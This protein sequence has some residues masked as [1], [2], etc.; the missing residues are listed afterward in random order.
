MERKRNGEVTTEFESLLH[1][2]SISELIA[3]D[4]IC[5]DIPPSNVLGKY[6]AS[7]ERN[8]HA[9]D[10]KSNFFSIFSVTHKKKITNRISKGKNNLV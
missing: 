4:I 3:S 9:E 5:Q 1:S 10:A 2:T 8:W 6:F 7:L